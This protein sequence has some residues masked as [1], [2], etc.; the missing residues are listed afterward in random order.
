M[1]AGSSGGIDPKERS[2]RNGCAEE[3]KLRLILL[4]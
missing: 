3:S 4:P 1:D 2:Q